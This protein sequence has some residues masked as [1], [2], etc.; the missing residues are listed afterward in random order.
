MLFWSFLHLPQVYLSL[1]RARG[2]GDEPGCSGYV[3]MAE[4]AAKSRNTP[5]PH[6]SAQG[7]CSHGKG[8]MQGPSSA[9]T[10]LAPASAPADCAI[11][12]FSHG[13]HPCFPF[14]FSAW[15]SC[16][17]NCWEP[18]CSAWIFCPFLTR[19]LGSSEVFQKTF[20]LFSVSY[21]G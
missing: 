9:P 7:W 1:Q 15:R 2:R 13:K 12:G 5:C 3:R 19:R 17:N 18:P 4:K 21:E 14:H 16:Y 20:V 6:P 8:W 11:Q 10:L